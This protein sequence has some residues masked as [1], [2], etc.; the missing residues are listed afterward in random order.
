MKYCVHPEVYG[1]PLGVGEGTEM[2]KTFYI[3]SKT[4]PKEREENVKEIFIKTEPLSCAT[5]YI[6]GLW[7]SQ[8]LS[9][10]GMMTPHLAGGTSLPQASQMVVGES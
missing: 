4:W 3:P 7:T 8:E 2:A 5:L 1:N 9:N 10:G 6:P